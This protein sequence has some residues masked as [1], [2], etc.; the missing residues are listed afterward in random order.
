MCKEGSVEICVEDS[1]IGI[2]KEKQHSLFLPHGF[3]GQGPEHSSARIERFL[4]LSANNNMQI[5]VPTTPANMFHLFGN[6][7]SGECANIYWY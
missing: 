2:R 7:L 6:I 1:G 4:E 3:E 5:V